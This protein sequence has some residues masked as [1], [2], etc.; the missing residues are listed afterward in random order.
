MR[1]WPVNGGR[2][3]IPNWELKRL[4]AV[5]EAKS[6]NERAEALRRYF[7]ERQI[8]KRYARVRDS[9]DRK[10]RTLVGAHVSQ[11]WAYI[12]QRAADARGMSVT[13]Y[14]KRALERA[15]RSDY[16]QRDPRGM[17]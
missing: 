2:T 11:E 4:G 10:R 9:R 3:T 1:E 12:V 7:D 6:Q 14:V 13:A 8:R 17:L 5:V 16:A 15:V